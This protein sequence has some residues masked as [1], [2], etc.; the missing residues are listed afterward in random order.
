MQA[1]QLVNL[2]AGLTGFNDF[3]NK[4]FHLT[5]TTDGVTQF[6]LIRR[7][8]DHHYEENMKGAL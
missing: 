1:V 2:C 4:D 7:K 3:S 6:V 5:S 8:D